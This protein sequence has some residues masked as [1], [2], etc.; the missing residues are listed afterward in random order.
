MN[1]GLWMDLLLALLLVVLAVQ[2]VI[3]RELFRSI[4]FFVAF[5]LTMALIWARLGAPDLALA[6][7]AIGAGLTGAL[8][9]A[10]FRRLVQIDP[11]HAE[12]RGPEH[13]GVAAVVAVLVA[14]LVATVGITALGLTPAA[15]S[16]GRDALARLPE[17]GLG[18]PVAGV[19]LVFRGFDTLVEMVVLLTAF[20][21]ARVVAGE[22]P[23][24][25]ATV[26]G[27]ELPLMRTLVAIVVPLTVLV[28][29]HLLWIGA[30]R[31]GGAFQA[32]SVLA[33]SGVLLTLTGNLLPT[34]NAPAW[35]RLGLVAGV[36][37]M[38][39][40]L[41]GPMIGHGVPMAWLGRGALLVAESLMTVAIA[42][43]LLL[44]FADAPGLIGARR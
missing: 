17:L 8:L 18:N 16:A 21:G 19:V 44:L 26:A 24:E 34:D 5:G 11:K 22:E 9:L 35:M 37:G 31:P 28:A 38:L 1:A 25:R 29:L 2:V 41:L 14:G 15:S 23:V 3:G 43:T 10:A 42:A 7:A 20:L 27:H 39:L 4:V 12:A 36:G 13:S 6:D 33:A 32:G 30:D 40:L